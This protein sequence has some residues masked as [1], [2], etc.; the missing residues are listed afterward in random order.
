ML[1]VSMIYC[2]YDDYHSDKDDNTKPIH[3]SG[4]LNRLNNE[5]RI[6]GKR[7]KSL[8]DK[9]DDAANRVNKN[10]S[11]SVNCNYF[12]PI[13]ENA[14][15]P[16]LEIRVILENIGGD[17]RKFDNAIFDFISIAKKPTLP[18]EGMDGINTAMCLCG[19]EKKFQKDTFGRIKLVDLL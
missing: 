8:V 7:I 1:K 12:Y 17:E 15:N 16:Y 13:T 2:I 11:G 6:D 10:Y 14:Q 5:N 18:E 4:L 9:I 19:E 3:P